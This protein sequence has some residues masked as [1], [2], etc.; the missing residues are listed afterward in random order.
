VIFHSTFC[1]D[2]WNC[3]VFVDMIWL[4]EVTRRLSSVIASKDHFTT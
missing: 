3:Y 2:P 1:H 4:I